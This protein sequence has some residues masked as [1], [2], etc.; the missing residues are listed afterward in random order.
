MGALKE[1][2]IFLGQTYTS[3]TLLILSRLSSENFIHFR[4][5]IYK[6]S[7]RSILV[8]VAVLVEVAH[9]QMTPVQVTLMYPK[10]VQM[11]PVNME[12]HTT[13]VA[14]PISVDTH[15]ISPLDLDLDPALECGSR[16][17]YFT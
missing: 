2:R 11:T 5:Y 6:F 3:L 4:C 13:I 16:S 7:S 12:V 17:C 1:I 15:S 10:L 8:E 14:E 9:M